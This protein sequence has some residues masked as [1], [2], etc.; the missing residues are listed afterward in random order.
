MKQLW[1]LLWVVLMLSMSCGEA[2]VY[3]SSY[4]PPE[5]SYCTDTGQCPSGQVCE[6]SVCKVPNDNPNPPANDTTTPLPPDQCNPQN[7]CAG[8]YICDSNGYCQP[9]NVAD[10]QTGVP[11]TNPTPPDTG[12]TEDV[13]PPPQPD[14][15]AVP[16]VYEACD[17]AD[18]CRV[19][20]ATGALICSET[21]NTNPK[22]APCG[23]HKD[24]NIPFGCHFGICAKYCELQFGDS[25]CLNEEKCMALKHPSWGA[26]VP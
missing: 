6:N 1:C 13:A 20:D 19:D 22:N 10:T 7:P 24:C 26:C 8:N 9:H 11:D 4:V 18:T 23:S 12:V 16:G 14:E 2:P 25:Q 5:Q 17:G 21:M 15:C 3:D